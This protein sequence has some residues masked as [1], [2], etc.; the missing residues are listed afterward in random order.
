MALAELVMCQSMCAGNA[1]IKLELRFAVRWGVRMDWSKEYKRERQV[2]IE[3]VAEYIHDTVSMENVIKLYCHELTP[4]HR[5]IPCPFHNGKDRNLSFGENYYKCFVC[6][7]AGDVVSFVKELLGLSTRLDA[8]KRLNRDLGLHL[9]LGETDERFS[10][11]AER[12]RAEASAK[13]SAEQKKLDDYH[14][15]LDEWIELDKTIRSSEPM[16]DEWAYAKK[17]IDA[18]AYA[19]DQ[20]AIEKG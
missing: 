5:R 10:A 14:R 6:G 19:L 12:R 2:T 17:R 4:R 15:L 1:N 3:D 7:A 13:R 18:V 8:M 20:I 9:P 11:E 16:S